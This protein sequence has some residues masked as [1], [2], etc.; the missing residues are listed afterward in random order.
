MTWDDDHVYVGYDGPDLD[1][2]TSDAGTK[3]L[4][5]YVDVDPGMGTGAT[6]SQGYNTQRA[7]FPAGFGAELYARWKA[8]GTYS[9]IEQHDAGSWSTSAGPLTTARAGQFLELAIPRSLLGSATEIGIVTWMINERALAESSWAGLY[10]DNFTDGYAESL[11]ITKYLRV[12]F[13]SS[14]APN[15]PLNAAP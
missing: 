8:D 13:A 10:A 1:P 4:F 9:S 6:Q 11:P 7:V 15:D 3:W 14:R 5:V 12:E 2:T